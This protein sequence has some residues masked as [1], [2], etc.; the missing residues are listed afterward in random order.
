MLYIDG[1]VDWSVRRRQRQR[2]LTTLHGKP[3]HTML[4]ERTLGSRCSQKSNYLEETILRERWDLL[5]SC[6]VENTSRL[7]VCQII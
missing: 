4:A 1:M 2:W 6:E 7:N 3:R 5:K